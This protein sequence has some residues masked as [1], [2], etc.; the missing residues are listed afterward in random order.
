VG[1]PYAGY[2]LSALGRRDVRMF[3]IA[4]PALLI[5]GFSLSRL[6]RQLGAEAERRAVE[7]AA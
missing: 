2:A 6:W 1:V 4:L 7:G 5:A 3:V